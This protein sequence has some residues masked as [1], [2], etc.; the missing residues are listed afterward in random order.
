MRFCCSTSGR[1]RRTFWCCWTEIQHAAPTGRWKA[2]YQMWNTD[3][4]RCMAWL[5]LDVCVQSD[6]FAEY[7]CDICRPYR[8]YSSSGLLM[9]PWRRWRC[10]PAFA[11]KARPSPQLLFPALLL[12]PFNSRPVPLS[13]S[14]FSI[15]PQQQRA[16]MD[17]PPQVGLNHHIT[18]DESLTDR[19]H[20]WDSGPA[21]VL[22]WVLAELGKYTTD[23]DRTGADSVIM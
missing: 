9:R 12:H 6:A 18:I 15:H 1:C 3:P 20:C 8:K 5:K 23:P 7:Q 2:A 17:D 10:R 11:S 14:S 13:P 19:L 21:Q 16:V 22:F 4:P